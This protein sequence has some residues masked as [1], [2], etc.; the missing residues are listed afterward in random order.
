MTEVKASP[1]KVG[2]TFLTKDRLLL[3]IV[4]ETT[5]YGVHM[6]IKRS[7]T[8]QVDACGLNRDTFY[9]HRNFGKNA[10]W[11]VTVCVVSTESISHPATLNATGAEK[12]TSPAGDN[13]SIDP[14]VEIGGQEGNPENADGDDAD[15]NGDGNEKKK[16]SKRQKS[17]M[18]SKYLVPLMKVVLFLQNGPT[19]LTKRW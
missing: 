11:K 18:K 5:L 8:F 6:A 19:F 9:V 16:K 7:D 14:L 10:S 1:L 15:D 3:R 2:D 17:P 13:N 4:E 12:R